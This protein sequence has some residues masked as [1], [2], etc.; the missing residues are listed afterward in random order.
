VLLRVRLGSSGSIKI[1]FLA[2]L[3][4]YFMRIYGDLWPFVDYKS[5]ILAVRLCFFVNRKRV[6]LLDKQ[7]QQQQQANQ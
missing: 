2:V 3:A 4:A 7:Q 5:S 1:G 6:C